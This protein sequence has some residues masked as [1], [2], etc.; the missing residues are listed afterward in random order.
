V[1]DEPGIMTQVATLHGLKSQIRD[2]VLCEA[3]AL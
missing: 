3:V 1:E 2:R